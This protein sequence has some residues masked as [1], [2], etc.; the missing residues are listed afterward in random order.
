M[1][2]DAEFEAHRELVERI[3]RGLVQQLDL[4]CDPDDLRAF[5]YEGILAAKKRFDPSRGVRFSTFAYYRV[6]GAVLDG[7]RAQ[8]FLKRRA[9]EKLKAIEAGDAVSEEAAAS[10]GSGLHGSLEARAKA[11]ED[12]L[13]K[14]SA[15][16][17]LSAVGQGDEHPP[18]TPESLVAA[19]EQRDVVK[20]G[21]SSLPEKERALLEAVYFEGVTLEQAGA[22]IGLSKSWASRLHAKALER[23]KKSTGPRLR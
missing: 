13:G 20:Q 9:Y 18:E 23:M 11:V 15:A 4:S 12:I 3:V 22:R 8:G 17:M 6:R 7:V 16:Y 14:I 5:G 1:N 21:L 19:A 10:G 2:D